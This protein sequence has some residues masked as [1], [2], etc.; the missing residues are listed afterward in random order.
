[1]PLAGDIWRFNFTDSSSA[2]PSV[3]RSWIFRIVRIEEVRTLLAQHRVRI[4]DGG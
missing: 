1:M 3:M 2:T 4:I